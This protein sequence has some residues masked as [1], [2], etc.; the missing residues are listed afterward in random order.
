MTQQTI[1]NQLDRLGYIQAPVEKDVDLSQAILDLKKEKNAVHSCALL[2]RT[3]YSRLSRLSRGQS[4][5]LAQA[6]RKS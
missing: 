2:S 1:S 5:I 6:S 4:Y 3:R